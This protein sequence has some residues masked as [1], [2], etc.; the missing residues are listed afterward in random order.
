MAVLYGV[1][2]VPPGDYKDG[3]AR[4]PFSAGTD[5]QGNEHLVKKMMTTK[6][7]LCLVA[8]ELASQLSSRHLDLN[9]AW[10]RRDTNAEAD[11]LTDEEFGAFDPAMRLDA[12]RVSQQF[13]VMNELEPATREWRR[14]RQTKEALEVTRPRSG[15]PLVSPRGRARGKDPGRRVEGVAPTGDP[16]SRTGDPGGKPVGVG[17]R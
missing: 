4:V 15:E 5:N 10:R 17:R 8:M 1:A 7:P 11:A 16:A 13:M 12:A 9:L 2:P 3:L 14:Q 6:F